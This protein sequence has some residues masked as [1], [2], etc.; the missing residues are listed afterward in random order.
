MNGFV[1][2]ADNL[3][4]RGVPLSRKF[5]LLCYNITCVCQDYYIYVSERIKV[6]WVLQTTY[7]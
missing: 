5:S 1:I 4:P 3:T 6:N 2:S 7:I